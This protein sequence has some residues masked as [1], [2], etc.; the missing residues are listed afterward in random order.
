MGKLFGKT[1]KTKKGAGEGVIGLEFWFWKQLGMNGPKKDN[2]KA[3]KGV[4]V[5]LSIQLKF[6][7]FVVQK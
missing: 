6:C 5:L 1:V 4:Q 3:K 7:P 2:L